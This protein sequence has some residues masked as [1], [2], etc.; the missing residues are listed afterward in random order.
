MTPPPQLSRYYTL[1]L[2]F[3]YP[4]GT[5]P[6]MNRVVAWASRN[7]VCHIEL[8]FENDMAFSIFEGSELFF[9][10]RT[11]SNPEYR[12]VALSV[13]KEEYTS[14]YTF[15]ENAVTKGFAFSDWAMWGTYFQIPGYPFVCPST[16]EQ[17]GSTCCSKIVTEAMLFARKI[18]RAHV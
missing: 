11:F 16:P 9:K 3:L 2:A 7:P 5:S 4:D 15:C 17:S 14:A 18:G 1:K 12:I 10:Q 8:V 13:S 6:F